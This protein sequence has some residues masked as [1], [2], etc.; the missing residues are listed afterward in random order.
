MFS[1]PA[2]FVSSENDR[3]ADLVIVVGVTEFL[4]HEVV[5]RRAGE[6]NSGLKCS[7]E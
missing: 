1:P 3:V 5:I 4:N 6:S 7:V 2:T